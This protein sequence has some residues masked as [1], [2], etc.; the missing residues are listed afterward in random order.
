MRRKREGFERKKATRLHK[1]SNVFESS[2]LVDPTIGSVNLVVSVKK[3]FKRTVS[4]KY[5]VSEVTPRK[6]PRVSK[7]GS[8][9]LGELPEI[10]GEAAGVTPWHSPRVLAF[11]KPS[12]PI[13]S[14]LSRKFKRCGVK[15]RGRAT[16]INKGCKKH[17]R[18]NAHAQDDD[19]DCDDEL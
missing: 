1:G 16:T 14:G 3:K 4:K 9:S 12:P 13:G 15:R 8:P 17:C 2:D 18:V 11:A 7:V 10:S 19:D 6:S 5:F